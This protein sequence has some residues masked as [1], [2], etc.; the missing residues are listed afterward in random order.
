[1]SSVKKNFLYNAA[2]QLLTVIVPLITTPHISRVLGADGVGRYSYNYSI[3]YYFV[4]F[5][6]LGLNNY[7]NREIARNN[8]SKK[9]LSKSFWS[10]YLFQLS[11][12]II[13]NVI[14][15]G[16]CIFFASDIHIALVL[17][18][19]TLSGVFDIN[20]FFFGIEEFKFITIR[21]T[22]IKLATTISIFIFVKDSDDVIIYT[23]IMAIGLLISQILLLPYL[24]K[25][26]NFC[27][28]EFADII[29]HIKPNCFLFLT[30]IAVSV[31]KILA[32][33]MLGFMTTETQVGFFESSERIIQVPM[34][35]VTALGTVM[36]PR[37]SNMVSKNK[38]KSFQTITISIIFAMFLSSSMC[39][40][41][42]GIAKE[43]VPVF[44]GPG[45]ETCVYIFLF[46]LPSCLFLAF[47]NVIR[48]QYVL[49]NQLDTIYVKSVF[50][51]ALVN[52]ALNLI[53]IPK[54]QAIGASIGTLMAEVAVCFYVVWRVRKELPIKEYIKLTC[55]FVVSG[56]IMFCFVFNINLPFDN[57]L[58]GLC[59][60]IGIG[61]VVYLITLGVQILFY[62]PLKKIITSLIK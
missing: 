13:I 6:T 22:I 24:F 25:K 46:L 59:A 23:L 9:N 21:N 12:G 41:I 19:Y 52:V 47:S 44:Y 14:Y 54:W 3:A 7:G 10:M 38:E 57:D 37:M 60:K 17:S 30:V 28:V 33:I 26:I 18:L 56:A 61:V 50:F 62:T 16:Y 49:P 31:Y 20:W 53:L 32:K 1:M 48:T 15:I 34:L 35:L 39:F 43:F 42:M 5:I 58:I 36:L 55:P 4:I 45:F 51:G 2:Y 11:I 8:T 27:K 29:R 40:G